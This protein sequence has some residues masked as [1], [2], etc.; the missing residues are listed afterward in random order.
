M[1]YRSNFTS[2]VELLEQIAVEGFDVFLDLIRIID[3]AAVSIS[4]LSICFLDAASVL[5]MPPSCG[6]SH[7]AVTKSL[8]EALSNNV[9]LLKLDII[10]RINLITNTLILGL[11]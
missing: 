9:R 5:W 4:T 8:A 6:G 7:A 1:T 2:P 10:C 11:K 3:N